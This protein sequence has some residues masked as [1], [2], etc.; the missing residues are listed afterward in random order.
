MQVI[1][2]AQDMMEQEP[3]QHTL[4]LLFDELPRE[5]LIAFE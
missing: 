4:P 2:M 5:E 3:V 1:Q